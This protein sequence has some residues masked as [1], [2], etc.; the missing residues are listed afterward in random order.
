[1]M[2]RVS[3]WRSISAAPASTLP[4][5]SM[6]T[7][8]SCRTAARRIRSRPGSFGSRPASFVIMMRMPTV[9]GV[10]F[11]SAM[12]SAT[13]GSSGS[14]GLTR[15][16]RP[17]GPVALPPHSWRRSGTWKGGDEDRAVDADP[18]HRR[19]HLVTR[20]VIGPVRHGVPGPFR[21]VRLIDVDLGID[22]RHREV[23]PRWDSAYFGPNTSMAIRPALTAQGQPA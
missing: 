20:D 2:N 9:P 12:T 5:H 14:T 3:G 19:H 23:P 4:Q 6:L 22:D 7:G 16:S 1:M 13:A 18:V 11:Q 8:K 15:A 10:F 17:D 21:R